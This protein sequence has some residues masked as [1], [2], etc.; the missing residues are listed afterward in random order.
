MNGNSMDYRNQD[1]LFD[2]IKVTWGATK[3][4]F[5]SLFSRILSILLFTCLGVGGGVNSSDSVELSFEMAIFFLMPF[6]FSNS[7]LDEK[8][9]SSAF[10]LAV[11]KDAK[12]Y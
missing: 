8:S 10:F 9:G 4:S 2:K 11:S 12:K 3:S 5:T 1:M 6:P 7:L